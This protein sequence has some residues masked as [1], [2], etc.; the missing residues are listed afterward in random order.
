VVSE[1]SDMI[2]VIGASDRCELVIRVLIQAD[3]QKLGKVCWVL[4]EVRL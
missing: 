2:S 1:G 4:N 3:A